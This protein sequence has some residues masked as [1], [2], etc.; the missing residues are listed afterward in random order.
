M[1]R[2]FQFSTLAVSSI[3]IGLYPLIYFIIDRKF[4]LLSSKSAELLSDISWNVGFY[5]HIL[6][7]GLALLI[8][9]TQFSPKWR[10]NKI[11]LHRNVGKAYIIFAFISSLAGI[12]IGFHATGGLV[13]KLGFI[14]LGIIWFITT[15]SAYLSIRKGDV[16][17]HQILMTYSYAACFAAVTLR[18]WLPILI[19]IFDGEFIPAYR[20]VAW[21][22]WVPNLIFAYFVVRRIK[23]VEIVNP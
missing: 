2:K 7:G 8:G 11:R 14:S 15:L 21:I 18:I 9:W 6:L 3:A 13:A 16:K 12:Y 20:I 23:G 5:S 17:T 1:L 4:G 10:K 19:N 22:S